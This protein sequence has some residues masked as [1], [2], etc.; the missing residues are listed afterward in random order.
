MTK[1]TSNEIDETSI[2]KIWTMI[3]GNQDSDNARYSY[4]SLGFQAALITLREA[5]KIK[6]D[7]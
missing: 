1:C 6:F 5:G 7:D 3:T 4:F 2:K